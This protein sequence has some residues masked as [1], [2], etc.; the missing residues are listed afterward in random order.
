[1]DSRCHH[2]RCPRSRWRTPYP[3]RRPRGRAPTP[4]PADARS[5]S[6]RPLLDLHGLETA[7]AFPFLL[8]CEGGGLQSKHEP[9][10]RFL[11]KTERSWVFQTDYRSD[12]MAPFPKCCSGSVGSRSMGPLTDLN[13]AHLSQTRRSTDERPLRRRARPR[14]T[15]PA[16]ACGHALRRHDGASAED[17]HGASSRP[18]RAGRHRAR[19]EPR[20]IPSGDDSRTRCSR[21]T[22]GIARHSRR[23][24]PLRSPYRK[25]PCRTSR[26]SGRALPHALSGPP[27]RHSA[28]PSSSTCSRASPGERRR[29]RHCPIG[30]RSRSRDRHATSRPESSR[31]DPE[32]NAPHVPLRRVPRP[33]PAKWPPDRGTGLRRRRPR[34]PGSVLRL[35]LRERS[36]TRPGPSRPAR[37]RRTSSDEFPP[38]STS[39]HLIRVGFRGSSPSAT[40]DTRSPPRRGRM[41]CGGTELNSRLQS[42]RPPR[43]APKQARARERLTK[44]LDA[45]R[46]ELEERPVAEITMDAIAERAG[47]PVGSLYQFFGSKTALLVEVAAMVMSEADAAMAR[48]LSECLTLP[49]REAVDKILE[50]SLGL[51]RDSPHYRQVLRSIRFTGEFAEVTEA[52]NRRVADLMSIH[53]GFAQAGIPR[54]K[55]LEICRTAVTAVNALQDRTLA[56]ASPDFD[57]WLDETKRLVKGYLGTYVA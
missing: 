17:A 9:G 30:A 10:S 13:G 6:S 56:E 2:R 49:W 51:L 4:P 11:P 26:S 28:R 53:P 40:P 39:D 43:P 25:G 3:A 15:D 8:S 24:S 32:K 50:T 14:A 31:S 45:T 37:V 23:R 57:S 48:E 44:I 35:P 12:S 46:A 54:N 34:R 16:S 1:M 22:T 47:V 21:S 20:H 42:R 33:M 18:A 27:G 41:A 29:D 55:A 52:S 36:R 5:T 38:D 19:E 7:N